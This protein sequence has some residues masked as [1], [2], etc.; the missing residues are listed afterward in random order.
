MRDRVILTESHVVSFASH[1]RLHFNEPRQQ[2][3]ILGPERLLEPDETAVAILRLLDGARSIAMM[4]DELA[5]QY[6]DAPR[7]QITKDV[8]SL[9]QGL[10][11]KG[12]IRHEPVTV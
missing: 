4:V 12:F 6:R 8:L 3:V 11:D 9:L 10:L 5:A 7:E 2:W 1:A